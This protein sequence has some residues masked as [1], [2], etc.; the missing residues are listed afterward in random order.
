MSETPFEQ[1]LEVLK[2]ND[3]ADKS[4]L[5]KYLSDELKSYTVTNLNY[6]VEKR[7]FGIEL[8]ISGDVSFRFDKNGNLIEV[9]N[10]RF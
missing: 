7:E 1:F 4:A 8:R 6:T 9:Q 10:H 2:S 5:V 3:K